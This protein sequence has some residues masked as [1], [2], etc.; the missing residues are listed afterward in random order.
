MT[1]Y[2]S[3]TEARSL[4][5]LRRIWP[6]LGGA[7]QDAIRNE[8]QN[9]NRISVDLLDPRVQVS[10]TGATATVTF[11]RHYVVSFPGQ[12][13]VQSDSHTVMEVRRNG[14]AWVIESIRFR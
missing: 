11:I 4:E 8:F 13:P 10:T 2:K 3:A 14:N 5:E 1:R 6:S 9:A 7:Q 12:G